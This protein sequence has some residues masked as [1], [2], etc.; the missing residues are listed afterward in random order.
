[1]HHRLRLS[2]KVLGKTCGLLPLGSGS[3]GLRVM[4]KGLEWDLDG[5]IESTLGGFLSTSNHLVP[6][7]GV[8][9]GTN[10]DEMVEVE[11]WNRGPEPLY[12]TVELVKD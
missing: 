2:R 1:G 4:T 12:W 8:E 7:S 11:V 5:S 3:E 10:P 6:A 9:E